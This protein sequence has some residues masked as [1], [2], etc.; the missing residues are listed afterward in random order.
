L[1]FVFFNQDIIF[2]ALALALW[3]KVAV[4]CAGSGAR[5]RQLIKRW[6]GT[7]RAGSR[8]FAINADA[9]A[10]ASSRR[11]AANA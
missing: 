1:F 10:Q 9:E 3:E 4:V 5:A 8:A 2:M 11:S 6:T 7:A